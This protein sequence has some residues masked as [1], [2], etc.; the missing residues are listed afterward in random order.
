MSTE[1]RP[2]Y[3]PPIYQEGVDCGTIIM[4]DAPPAL[5]RTLTLSYLDKVQRF[6]SLII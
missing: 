4:R 3:L 6:F 5:V 2:I 1:V